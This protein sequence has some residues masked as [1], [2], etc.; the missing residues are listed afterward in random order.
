MKTFDI[1][2]NINQ[3]TY[4]DEFVLRI[5]EDKV[6]KIIILDTPELLDLYQEIKHTVDTNI[7]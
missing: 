2:V 4:E 3:E 7:C 6:S 5:I 1:K